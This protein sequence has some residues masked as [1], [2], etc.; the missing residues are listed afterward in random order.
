MS[1][2]VQ[3]K[4]LRGT[5]AGRVDAEEGS[6]TEG[7]GDSVVLV[8]GSM[9]GRVR[10]IS[11][12]GVNPEGKGTLGFIVGALDEGLNRDDRAS[13]DVDRERFDGR[14]DQ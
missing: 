3:A 8:K 9:A 10:G 5:F 2:D 11:S 12:R 4:T 14:S 7:E 6:G 13:A 1:A